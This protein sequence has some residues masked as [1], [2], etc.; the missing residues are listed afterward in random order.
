MPP[1]VHHVGNIVLDR[2]RFDVVGV[3]A[4]WVVARVPSHSI[5][6]K[7]VVENLPSNAMSFLYPSVM[8]K[9]SISLGACRSRPFPTF[10]VGL[11]HAN[12]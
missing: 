11:R 7:I 8:L 12:F 1:A 2:A 3:A 10:S 4:P 9:P 5:P 6:Q